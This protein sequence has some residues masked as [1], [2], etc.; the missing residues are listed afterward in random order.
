M[1]PSII[2][3]AAAFPARRLSASAYAAAWGA[4]A[5]RGLERKPFCG[6]DEDAISLGVAAGRAALAR[7]DQAPQVTALFLGS[8]TLPYEEKPASA[9]VVTAL[10]DNH[11][12]RTVEI[13]GSAQAGLQA[14]LSAAEYCAA[15]PGVY[16]IAIASDAPQA[17]A[18]ASIEH[19]LAAGAAAF[20]VG[21]APGMAEI[22]EDRAITTETFGSRFR[23]NG[24]KHVRDLE[25]RVSEVGAAARALAKFGFGKIERAALG[26]SPDVARAVE[27]AFGVTSDGLWPQLG[28]TGAAGTPIAL[29]HVLETAAIGETV[30]AAAV[31][32]GATALT[33]RRTQGPPLAPATPVVQ[34]LAGGSEVDYIGYLKHRRML[35]TADMAAS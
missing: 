10:F 25:L 31:A 3:L 5:A 17:A 13:R 4:N 6:F 18:D 27:Q 8:T 23:R 34:Q 24:E 32:S 15:H 30:L 12:I 9:T 26:A 22:G 20:V 16:A 1:T 35:G 28:D 19:A 21:P 11:A 7:L 2:S 29:V 33:L 14:L